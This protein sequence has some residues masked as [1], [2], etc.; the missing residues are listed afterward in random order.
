MNIHIAIVGCKNHAIGDFWPLALYGC[1][2]EHMI[3]HYISR[4]TLSRDLY[5][6]N[7]NGSRL[8]KIY[9]S[10]TNSG[11]IIT[12]TVIRQEHYLYNRI[13]TFY[14]RDLIGDIQVLLCPDHFAMNNS[15]REEQKVKV[16]Y[17]LPPPYIPPGFPSSS[18]EENLLIEKIMLSISM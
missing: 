18:V 12:A 2:C 13:N 14:L 11:D 5:L 6:A 1:Y 4:L 3:E 15:G 8:D 10:Y 9:V 17:Q 16:T 7:K